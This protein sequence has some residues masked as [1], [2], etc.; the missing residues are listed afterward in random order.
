LILALIDR[1]EGGEK[2]EG[3]TIHR[4]PSMIHHIIYL[5]LHPSPFSREKLTIDC[6]APMGLGTYIH[7]HTSSSYVVQ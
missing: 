3:I 2:A 6:T 7:I 5:Y 1:G 4:C